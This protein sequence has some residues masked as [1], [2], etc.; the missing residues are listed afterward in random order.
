MKKELF[1]LTIMLCTANLMAQ[2]G[3][4]NFIVQNYIEV[5]G[6]SEMEISPDLIYIKVLLDEKDTKN[7]ENLS[8]LEAK[9]TTTLEGIGIN[10]KE[11]LL[12]KDISSNFK[13][14]LLTRNKIL[15]S[16]EYQILVR[17][18]KTASQ[19]FISL[20]NIGISNVSIDRL[21]HSKIVQLRKDVKVNAIKAGK[22]KAES[23]ALAI[24][25]NVGRALY[26]QERDN[27]QDYRTSN[28]I[29]IRGVSSK[30]YGSNAAS[31]ALDFDFEKIKIAYSILCRFELE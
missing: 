9:M 10:T 1:M 12:I 23:L 30:I 24:G 25:Q 15:L 18:G 4:K 26:I 17:D 21:D 29:M 8:Q 22:D 7:K 16:K 27:M 6:K 3:D 28:N 31:A 13:Y 11:D 14:Y 19:V 5:I 20:E 2:N